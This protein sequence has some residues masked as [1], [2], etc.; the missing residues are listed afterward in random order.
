MPDTLRDGYKRYPKGGASS[1]S[2][3]MVDALA[4]RAKLTEVLK[5][6]QDKALQNRIECRMTSP[7]DREDHLVAQAVEL[8]KRC[9]YVVQ[10][11]ASPP[12]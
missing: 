4:A 2:Q 5:G 6:I 11:S 8:R 10:D 7:Q 3:G 1:P 9:D 12:S